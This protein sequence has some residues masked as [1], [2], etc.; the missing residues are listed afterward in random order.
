MRTSIHLL[1]LL[2][3][4]VSAKNERKE[5]IL[6][7]LEESPTYTAPARP[8]SQPIERLLAYSRALRE[9][10]PTNS[11]ATNFPSFQIIALKSMLRSRR[12]GPPIPRPPP[13][14]HHPRP[15][16]RRLLLQRQPTKSSAPPTRTP[17]PPSRFVVSHLLPKFKLFTSGA[18]FKRFSSLALPGDLLGRLDHRP[19]L[20]SRRLGSILG[21]GGAVDPTVASSWKLKT[22]LLFPY[23]RQGF[24]DLSCVAQPEI[25]K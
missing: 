15:L 13:H 23:P 18:K 9:N 7:P 8:Q 2:S 19:R 14:Q 22:E 3:A 10:L 20:T 25:G 6:L 5:L 24:S 4:A 17:T 11:P 16:L 12:R 21:D 1:L